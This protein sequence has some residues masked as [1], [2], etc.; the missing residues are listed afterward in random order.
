MC[1][2]RASVKQ[3]IHYSR[4]LY[5][6]DKTIRVDKCMR[7]LIRL[8]NVKGVKTLGCCCGHQK[9]PMTIVFELYPDGPIMELMTRTEIPRKTKFYKMDEEG[10][11][12]IPE[13]S[14]EA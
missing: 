14:N 5:S 12:Y 10:F 7:N 4:G 3:N 13:V 1:D 11:F 2:K 9:Y 6:Y 8:L